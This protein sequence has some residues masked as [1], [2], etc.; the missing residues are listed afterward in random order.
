MNTLFIDFGDPVFTAT[1]EKGNLSM[2]FLHLEPNEAKSVHVDLGVLSSTFSRYVEN[3]PAKVQVAGATRPS[4]SRTGLF[5]EGSM[6]TGPLRLQL[7]P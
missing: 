4:K 7:R 3:R 6:Q 5:W 2:I 1:K